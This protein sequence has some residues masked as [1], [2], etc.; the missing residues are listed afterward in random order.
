MDMAILGTGIVG[1]TI[2]TKLIQLGHKVRMGSRKA[3]NEKAVEWAKANGANASEGTFADAAAFGGLV[4]NCT[5]GTGSLDA[6]K[7]AGAANLKGKA[8]IDVSNPLDFSKGMPPS[9][10]VCNTDSL[11]EQIQRTFPES[12]VV[13]A[14]NTTNALLMVNPGSLADGDHSMFIC[15][16]DA[17]AKAKVTDLLKSG[18]GWKDVIDLG[19]ITASRGQEM[20]LPLW[21]RLWGGLKTPSFNYKIVR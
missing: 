16:N 20:I 13:K 7:Q 12:K 2:G 8:I 17:E 3:G 19:D 11:G 6:L 1:N 4:F 15:G 9:L 5:S 14:L 10:S 18:F 21:L